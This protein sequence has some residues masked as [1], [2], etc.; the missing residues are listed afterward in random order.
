MS[1]EPQEE[2]TPR[3]DAV[4]DTSFT[5][6]EKLAD[7]TQLC[8]E[9]ERDRE[10]IARVAQ[11][12]ANAISNAYHVMLANTPVRFIKG[13]EP[14]CPYEIPVVKWADRPESERIEWE[15]KAAW[16]RPGIE[17]MPEDFVAYVA[18]RLSEANS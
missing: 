12:Q 6:E 1:E 15:I 3:T 17:P 8:R 14:P 16:N 5:A 9:L 4:L 18:A 11:A 10:T 7:M 13:E 2:G